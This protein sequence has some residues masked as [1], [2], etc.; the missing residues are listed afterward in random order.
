MPYKLIYQCSCCSGK[1]FIDPNGVIGFTAKGV[2][3]TIPVSHFGD[4]E[5]AAIWLVLTN[6]LGV[7]TDSNV[8]HLVKTYNVIGRENLA[9]EH[10]QKIFRHF[11]TYFERNGV[12][13]FFNPYIKLLNGLEVDG[14]SCTF[15][16]GRI[17]A[18]DV[19]KCP[20]IESWQAYVKKKEGKE[21]WWNCLGHIRETGPN[22]FILE[23]IK[24]HNPLVLIFA[25][26]TIGLIGVEYKGR[27]DGNLRGFP[28]VKIFKRSQN[29]RCISIDLGSTRQFRNI[30]QDTN[31]TN[32]FRVALQAAINNFF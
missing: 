18:V 26:C 11:S 27:R 31:T 15:E 21:V 25:Q 28:D 16:N 2:N 32:R 3:Q 14:R 19:I 29:Q 1:D 17:C 10:I 7:R 30:V 24:K 8:G 23:Q 20:T 22:H 5:K 6:P 4:I 12:N 9:D 13:S